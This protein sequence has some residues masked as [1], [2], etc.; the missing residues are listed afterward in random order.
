MVETNDQAVAWCV[1]H[2]VDVSFDNKIIIWDNLD[3]DLGKTLGRGATLID[4]VNYAI[5]RELENAAI[6]QQQAAEH[7]QNLE[8]F[9]TEIEKRGYTTCEYEKQ[10]RSSTGDAYSVSVIDVLK[11][12]ACI[13]SIE[14]MWFSYHTASNIVKFVEEEMDKRDAR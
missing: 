7:A 8:A 12:D 11:H 2:A 14:K 10:M 9:K 6:Q 1:K 4:A 3:W 5:Q 13:M